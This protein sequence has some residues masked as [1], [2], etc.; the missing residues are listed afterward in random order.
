MTPATTNIS[1]RLRC[2][3]YRNSSSKAKHRTAPQGCRHLQRKP[4]LLGGIRSAGL[5]QNCPS[6]NGCLL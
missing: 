6:N 3:S 2:K 5:C 1:D 4:K